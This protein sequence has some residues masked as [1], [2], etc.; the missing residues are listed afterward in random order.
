[1]KYFK[2][3]VISIIVLTLTCCEPYYYFRIKKFYLENKNNDELSNFKH[4]LIWPIR[5]YLYYVDGMWLSI[6]KSDTSIRIPSNN[7]GNVFGTYT[8][9]AGNYIEG[10]EKEKYLEL[11]RRYDRLSVFSING[12]CSKSL[13]CIEFEVVPG[14]Y[15]LYIINHAT[16]HIDE[17]VNKGWQRIDDS[18]YYIHTK[19]D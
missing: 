6:I 7:M 15:L 16:F 8:D 12:V 5:D 14:H 3:F 2:T 9:R 10:E 13:S 19:E 18:W 1:L 4:H 11:F 17:Y